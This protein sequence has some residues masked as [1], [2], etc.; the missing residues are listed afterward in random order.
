MNFFELGMKDGLEKKA[1]AG[2]FGL[3]SGKEIKELLTDAAW[4]AVSRGAGGAA[5]GAAGAA[6]TLEAARMLTGAKI[7]KKDRETSMREVARFGAGVGGMIGLRSMSGPVDRAVR[8]GA[9]GT[10]GFIAALGLGMKAIE[11][12]NRHEKK[13]GLGMSNPFERQKTHKKYMANR[14][15]HIQ[16]SRLYRSTHKAQISR[17][18]KKYR[19]QIRM[20][21]RRP[22]KRVGSAG[23][24]VSFMAR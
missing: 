24:G 1:A 6:V 19:S 14:F 13:A 20:K 12:M 22:R 10:G 17:K 9:V 16:Q 3:K 4:R 2:R 11:A 5:G 8:H 7:S 15:S 23:G 18:T 21:V